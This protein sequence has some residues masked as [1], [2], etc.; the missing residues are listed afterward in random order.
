MSEIKVMLSAAFKEAYLEL[1]P[2]FKVRAD[3]TFTLAKDETAHQELLRR[4]RHKASITATW[5]PI[6]KLTLSATL[7]YVGE[8]MD[9]NRD[10]SIARL[11]L[12]R[13]W[14]PDPP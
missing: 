5:M 6:E 12:S 11:R 4:P 7:I 13:G 14:G 10:F 9:G 2:Q 3:Y 1:T 8:R